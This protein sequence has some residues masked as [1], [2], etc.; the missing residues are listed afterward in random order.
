MIRTIDQESFFAGPAPSPTPDQVRLCAWTP[1]RDVACLLR[2]CELHQPKRFLEIG[3]H[4]GSTTLLLSQEFPEMEI[5]GIDPG[6][7]VAPAD[8]SPSQRGEY[9]RPE[10]IGSLVAD[11]RHVL[12]RRCT[13]ND[14]PTHLRFDAIFV[15][16]DHRRAAILNDVEQSLA[17]LSPG[18]LLAFHDVGNAIVPDVESM[19]ES[20]PIEIT[21][22]ENSWIAFYRSP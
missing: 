13:I 6:Q 1:W 10:Q 11:R 7:L 2:L 3:L 19:L 22:I 20:L 15:D 14:L 9:L 4:R 18:G 8:R 12:V 21:W 16:G 5:L 17:R